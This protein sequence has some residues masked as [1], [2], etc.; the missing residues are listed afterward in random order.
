MGFFDFFKKK[1]KAVEDVS[2][3]ENEDFIREEASD[4]EDFEQTVLTMEDITTQMIKEVLDELQN[5][6]KR[7]VIYIDVHD[8]ETGLFESKFGGLPY[9][10]QSEDVPK[11]SSGRQLR[12]LAQ[13]NLSELPK[14][15]FM[16]EQGMLQFWAVD[17]DVTGANFEN[18]NEND[19]S[20]VIY[21]NDIDET[22]T[23]EQI[24]AKYTPYCEDEGYFPICGEFGLSFELAEE[25][26]S[27]NSYLFDKLF[28]EKWNKRYPDCKI[29]SFSELPEDDNEDLLSD[30][31][32]FGHKI[33]GYP[34]FTQCDP[35]T[36]DNYLAG[37]SQLLLQIDS[38]G[39]DKNEIM[40]GDGGVC[41]F[42]IKPDDLK[43]KDFSK[44]AYNWDCY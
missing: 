7:P 31:S 24:E 3:T 39:T 40:W 2:K 44:T 5:E 19:N 36:D 41:N 8:G 42:F 26:I 20:R 30:L 22:V 25:G 27:S 38:M 33:G 28:S 16:P 37:Y 6:T 1:N 35:R 23:K 34:A 29:E 10:P 17:D 13:I 32:G 12:L 9:I 15:D 21:W 14:N 18:L 11:D 43:N 4:E